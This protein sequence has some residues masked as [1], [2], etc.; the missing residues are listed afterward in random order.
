MYSSRLTRGSCSLLSRGSSDL[1]LQRHGIS[2][3][4][5]CIAAGEL[6]YYFAEMYRRWGLGSFAWGLGWQGR[7]YGRIA[8][9]ERRVL[10]DCNLQEREWGRRRGAVEFLFFWGPRGNGC[11][12]TREALD[13]AIDVGILSREN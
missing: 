7:E 5:K 10:Q 13:D 11:A 3:S 6:G 9:A 2:I 4:R 1:L 8:E 12:R